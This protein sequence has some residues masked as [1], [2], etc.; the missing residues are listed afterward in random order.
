MLNKFI[1]LLSMA[2]LST[3]S[4]AET[5]YYDPAPDQVY[6]GEIT[7]EMAKKKTPAMLPAVPPREALLKK[8]PNAS[9]KAA[10]PV[11]ER[12]GGPPI[13][14]PLTECQA[15]ILFSVDA[16]AKL[17]GFIMRSL[18]VIPAGQMAD[19]AQTVT[20]IFRSKSPEEIVALARPMKGVASSD[21]RCP[22]EPDETTADEEFEAIQ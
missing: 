20:D 21:V 7:E 15:A 5:Q 3:M 12:I 4:V 10:P 19:G 11:N 13:V 2:L 9:V 6:P 16:D 1:T 17:R 22:E 8:D 18:N 14:T